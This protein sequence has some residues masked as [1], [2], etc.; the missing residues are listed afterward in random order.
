MVRVADRVILRVDVGFTI[1]ARAAERR[2]VEREESRTATPAAFHDTLKA[3]SR[4]ADAINMKRLREPVR[5]RKRHRRGGHDKRDSR[6]QVHVVL[7]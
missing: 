7:G 6:D 3:R 1:R 4:C 2:F 5:K